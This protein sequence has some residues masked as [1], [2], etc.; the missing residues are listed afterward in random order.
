MGAIDNK[1]KMLQSAAKRWQEL[2][3]AER[4]AV[5]RKWQRQF[6]TLDMQAWMPD[7]LRCLGLEPSE[8]DWYNTIGMDAFLFASTVSQ[9]LGS[10][11]ERLEGKLKPDSFKL[12]R[13][14]SEN[15]PLVYALGDVDKNAAPGCVAELWAKKDSEGAHGE[16]PEEDSI[17][18]AGK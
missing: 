14:L 5:A 17:S 4:A 7:N 3:D 16:R 9:R 2:S 15:G 6:R 1:L 11:A 13:Q 10:I 18:A 12:D 8:H